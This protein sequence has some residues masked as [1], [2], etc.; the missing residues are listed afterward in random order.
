MPG[1]AD[2]VHL[3]PAVG[4]STWTGTGAET[5]PLATMESMDGPGWSPCPAVKWVHSARRRDLRPGRPGYSLLWMAI[6][7]SSGSLFSAIWAAIRTPAQAS[8]SP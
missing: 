7:Q 2:L 6:W 4:A 3:L 5:I 1:T 8:A